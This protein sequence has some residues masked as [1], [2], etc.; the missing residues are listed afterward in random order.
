MQKVTFTLAVAAF[1]LALCALLRPGSPKATAAPDNVDRWQAERTY[2]PLV[3]T[4]KA[5]LDCSISSTQNGRQAM[6]TVTGQGFTFDTPMRPIKEGKVKLQQP[7]MF[8]RFDAF[9]TA[10]IPAQFKGLG[11]GTITAMKAEVEVDVKRFQQP[12]GPG[13]TIRFNAAD[14]SSDAAYVE[15]TG[16]FVRKADG[17]RFPFR[18]LFGSVQDGG[19]NVTPTNA[20]PESNIMAKTVVLGSRRRPATVTTALYE[21]EDDVATLQVK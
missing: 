12:G 9:P 2:P 8:Y 6:S 16:V 21:A 3:F 15:F 1:A 18:V 20:E 17:K 11:E 5:W 14:I 13:T 4:S 7:G 10:A 19:G